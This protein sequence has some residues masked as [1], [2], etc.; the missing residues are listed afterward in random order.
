MNGGPGLRPAPRRPEP[1]G[2][3]GS[4]QVAA[5][6][7]RVGGRHANRDCRG[8]LDAVR[9]G[10]RGRLA[11]DDDLIGVGATGADRIPG[12]LGH[13]E[14]GGPGDDRRQ[15]D[16]CEGATDPT[17]WRTAWRTRWRSA[18][19]PSHGSCLSRVRFRNESNRHPEVLGPVSPGSPSALATSWRPTD[20]CLPERGRSVARPVSLT[21]RVHSTTE[22]GQS[23]AQVR[24]R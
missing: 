22:S 20:R 24:A 17:G 10:D 12:L 21:E 8:G 5:L 4:A 16:P 19:C 15:G 2:R 18:R 7:H 1:C 9:V 11:D 3:F 6:R 13:E 23:Q 14:H